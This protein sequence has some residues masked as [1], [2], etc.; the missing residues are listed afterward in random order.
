M[1]NSDWLKR[2]FFPFFFMVAL[3]F[4][5]AVSLFKGP[6]HRSLIAE[7]EERWIDASL[8]LAG[9]RIP[10]VK[11]N[12]IFLSLG[13][14]SE[15]EKWRILE[16]IYEKKPR[17]V[18]LFYLDF[19]L[20]NKEKSISFKNLLERFSAKSRTVFTFDPSR[21][22]F[23]EKEFRNFK[24]LVL[25]NNPCEIS[26]QRICTY[27]K[28][29]KNWIGNYVLNT[30]FRPKEF[31]F[32]SQEL[33]RVFPSFL[34]YLAPTQDL[35]Y[36]E[37]D[38]LEH[39]FSTH[40]LEG[41]IVFVDFALKKESKRE[42]E[43]ILHLF[44]KKSY[45]RS[46]FWYD[47]LQQTLD[48]D[49]ISTVSSYYRCLI[50]IF[51]FFLVILFVFVFDFFGLFFF[52]FMLLLSVLFFNSFSIFFFRIY[53]PFG[54]GSFFLLAFALI[55]G[56]LKLSYVSYYRELDLLREKENQELKKFRRI[57]LSIISHN[58]NTP[59]A[60]IQGLLDL[61]K[62]ELNEEDFFTQDL[63][64][65]KKALGEA[66][67]N[68]KLFLTIIS[69]Q[70]KRISKSY[71]SFKDFLLFFKKESKLCL[72]NMGIKIN[73]FYDQGLMSHVVHGSPAVISYIIFCF[74]C[75]FSK[76]QKTRDLDL[77]FSCEDKTE[78]KYILFEVISSSPVHESYFSFESRETID[79]K[80]LKSLDEVMLKFFDAIKDLVEIHFFYKE[81]E[82]KKF[83]IN[84]C[85]S[86]KKFV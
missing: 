72:E 4:F 25:E 11:N 18:F 31:R 62:N 40:S 33:Y 30:F 52:T 56:F 34:V 12:Q 50:W 29:R 80:G 20:K 84:V 10:K 48:R 35:F 39:F 13:Y 60:Q 5:L 66:Y 46:L 41:K 77:L 9:Q 3:L 42:K 2:I 36:I 45:S 8:F 59:L 63:N 79:E 86:F 74:S 68:I 27:N 58:L 75:F 55:G 6:K 73:V 17:F 54:S 38:D 49:F 14:S 24:M 28:A 67:L 43:K 61:V 22:R 57:V 19:F 71:L 69:I 70:S 16:K 23:L 82:N 44:S 85:I 47:F 64:V 53:M 1:R 81:K 21:S 51:S 7:V 78:D 32:F 83:S 37:G 65:I 26:Q 76:K 15:E